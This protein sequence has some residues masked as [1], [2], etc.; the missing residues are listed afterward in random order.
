MPKIGSITLN[1]ASRLQ[2][3]FRA[4]RSQAQKRQQTHLPCKRK[5]PENAAESAT[6]SEHGLKTAAAASEP[7]QPSDPKV[8]FPG[9]LFCFSLFFLP[10]FGGISHRSLAGLL[11]VHGGHEREQ[12][13]RENVEEAEDH[14]SWRG[15][16]IRP[17][18]R[19]QVHLPNRR[20]HYSNRYDENPMKISRNRLS[21]NRE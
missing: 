15:A 4:M 12:N 9:F 7:E 11:L 8:C 14:G 3:L 16:V 19:H 20:L 21:W 18:N 2:A 6:T 13:R 1:S 10:F 17:E 5:V